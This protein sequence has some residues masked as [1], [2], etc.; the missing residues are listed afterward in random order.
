MATALD[1]TV[2]CQATARVGMYSNI[3]AP[4]FLVVVSVDVMDGPG[5][6]GFKS[7]ESEKLVYVLIPKNGLLWRY[8]LARLLK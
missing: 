7:I 3:F 2:Q 1:T 4:A 5:R 8:F 6:R